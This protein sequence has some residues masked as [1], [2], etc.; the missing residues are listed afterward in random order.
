MG[1][2]LLILVAQLL[3][4][5]VFIVLY[6]CPN[7]IEKVKVS[8]GRK[9]D[10]IFFNA[11]L[12]FIDGTFLVIV[13]MAMIN[14]DAVLH[15]HD[16]EN[17]SYYTALIFCF[18]IALQY[19]G[20][21]LFFAANRRSLKS[22]SNKKCCGY[23]YEEL[24]YNVRGNMALAFP[25]LAQLRLAVMVYTIM[26]LAENLVLQCAIVTLTSVFIASL[27]GF[28]HPY[29]DISKNFKSI[30]SEGYVLI[31]LDFL[32]FSSNPTTTVYE[33]SLYGWGMIGVVGI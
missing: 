16:E 14:I 3:L 18:L 23:I 26:F 28:A 4:V 20:V 12:A 15:G 5:L 9:V 17:I 19:V 7:C 13:L 21:F 1:S 30:V 2:L 25:L 22:E 33:R 32:L 27:L 31:V 6:I 24:N 10:S 8:M 11:I 29:G